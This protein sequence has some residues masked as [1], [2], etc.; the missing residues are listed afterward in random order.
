MLFIF[1]LLVHT[2][3]AVMT[4]PSSTGVSSF[5]FFFFRSSAIWVTRASL[6][7]DR[8]ARNARVEPDI[9]TSHHSWDRFY[10]LEWGSL[11]VIVANVL[12][13][14]HFCF[15]IITSSILIFT[16]LFGSTWDLRD[17]FRHRNTGVFARRLLVLLQPTSAVHGLSPSC[18]GQAS[19]LT[20]NN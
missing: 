7:S 8:N 5:F 16:D 6:Q 12:I 13:T 18:T 3:N 15:H 2:C 17:F 9:W 11:A 14:I 20:Q 19:V 1:L 10:R 4:F